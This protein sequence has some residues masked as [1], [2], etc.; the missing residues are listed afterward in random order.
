MKGIYCLV[1]NIHEKM[2]I[3]VGALGEIDFEKGTYI[4]VG[5]AQNNL[6]KRNLTGFFVE[7]EIILEILGMCP[8]RGDI[9][10]EIAIE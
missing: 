3:E 6:K 4:Y 1:I 2:K 9:R 8:N 5:S 10:S 7:L